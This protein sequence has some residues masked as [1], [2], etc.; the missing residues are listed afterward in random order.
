MG[1]KKNDSR[2]GD[3]NSKDMNTS[4][5]D[6]GGCLAEETRWSDGTAKR[7]STRAKN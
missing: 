1:D 2:K 7:T 6:G 4:N 3:D 5:V